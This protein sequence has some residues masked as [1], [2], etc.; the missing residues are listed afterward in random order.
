MKSNLDIMRHEYYRLC[1][2]IT[3]ICLFSKP[4]E[5]KKKEPLTA[6]VETAAMPDCFMKNAGG[7]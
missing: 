7:Q 1:H 6:R 5:K 3:V 2:M 4:K